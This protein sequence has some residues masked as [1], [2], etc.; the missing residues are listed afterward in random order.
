MEGFGTA[1]DV[2]KERYCDVELEDLEGVALVV[3]PR[4]SSARRVSRPLGS[5]S[6]WNIAASA[7]RFK[8]SYGVGSSFNKLGAS[9]M[10]TKKRV[11]LLV[12]LLV[13]VFGGGTIL[14][15]PTVWLRRN[16]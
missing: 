13:L 10:V 15:R 7:S 2:I 5:A 3:D 16:V 11:G 6:H 8:S 12:T 9:C 14:S 4:S 1:D